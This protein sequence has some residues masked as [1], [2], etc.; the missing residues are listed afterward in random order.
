MT[1]NIHMI[2]SINSW[3]RENGSG[4]LNCDDDIG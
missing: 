2:H 1:I 4:M 3:R